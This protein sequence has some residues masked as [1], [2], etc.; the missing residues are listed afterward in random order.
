M[1]TRVYVSESR[2]KLMAIIYQVTYNASSKALTTVPHLCVVSNSI[3]EFTSPEI[4]CVFLRKK[5]IYIY[6]L[7]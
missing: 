1:Y 7:H 4:V 5:K 6:L 2:S 3:F